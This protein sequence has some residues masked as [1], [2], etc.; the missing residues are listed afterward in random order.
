MQYNFV[1]YDKFWHITSLVT[2]RTHTL[3]EWCHAIYLGL[4]KYSHTGQPQGGETALPV[5]NMV[6]AMYPHRFEIFFPYE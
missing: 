2:L 3:R 4:Q 5:E 1:L 6:V